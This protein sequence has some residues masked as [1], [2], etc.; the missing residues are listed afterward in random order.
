[1]TLTSWWVQGP[2]LKEELYDSICKTPRIGRVTRKDLWLEHLVESEKY[3]LMGA[4]VGDDEDI[5]K[6]DTCTH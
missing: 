3:L 5:L 6:L 1:M 2:V 4:S